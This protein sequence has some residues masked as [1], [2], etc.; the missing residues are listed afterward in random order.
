MAWDSIEKHEKLLWLRSLQW[1]RLFSDLNRSCPP[2]LRPHQPLSL[3]W[4]IDRWRRWRLNWQGSHGA[5]QIESAQDSR[6]FPILMHWR[7][8]TQLHW[9]HSAQSAQGIHDASW[10][11]Y[12]AEW[13]WRHEYIRRQVPWW[14]SVAAPYTCW[15][16]VDSES[17]PRYQ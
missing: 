17:R 6:E 8:G 9:Q 10:R 14:E 2:S 7:K 12:R 15:T 11:H 4:P 1:K 3:L 16:I 5:F 13:D